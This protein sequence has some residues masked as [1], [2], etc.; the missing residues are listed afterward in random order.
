MKDEI[1]Y[2]L[3][4]FFLNILLLVHDDWL[5]YVYADHRLIWNL[6]ER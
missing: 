5:G 1:D 2:Q 3:F 6:L 4:I